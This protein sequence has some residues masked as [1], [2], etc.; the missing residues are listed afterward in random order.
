MNRVFQ[1]CANGL[2]DSFANRLSNLWSGKLRHTFAL[3]HVKDITHFAKINSFASF[4]LVD[5]AFE[6]KFIPDEPF[7]AIMRHWGQ[8]HTSALVSVKNEVYVAL[9][10]QK[11]RFWGSVR[12]AFAQFLIKYVV[13][14][15]LDFFDTNRWFFDW[16][17]FALL[18]VKEVVR[19][20]FGH[21]QAFL[22]A[23][24]FADLF[25]V[26]DACAFVQRQGFRTQTFWLHLTNTS[27]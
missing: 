23:L 13:W 11:T 7:R 20:A 27:F 4:A 2:M 21:Y 9:D 6:D 14:Q 15:T 19:L 10:F 22:F 5:N 25:L 12:N 18:T 26:L 16:N 8:R 3:F 24:L 1:S 17:A